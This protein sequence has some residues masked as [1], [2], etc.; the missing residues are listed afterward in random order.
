MA[1]GESGLPGREILKTKTKEILVLNQDKEMRSEL[2]DRLSQKGFAVTLMANLPEGE[3]ALEKDVYDLVVAHVNACVTECLSF[4][5]KGKKIQPNAILIIVA[6][7][8]S[9]SEAVKALYLGAADLLLDPASLDDVTAAIETT[10]LAKETGL[11]TSRFSR[12]LEG[13]ERTFTFPISEAPLGPTVDLL[14][15]NLVRAGVCTQI[16]QRLVAMAL[17]EALGNALYH[18]NLEIDPR[19][20]IDQGKEAFS[21]EVVKRL[22]DD[23]YKKRK[24]TVSY[25]ITPTEARF[26]IHD[27][28]EGFDH[29]NTKEGVTGDLAKSE[30]RGLLFLRSIMDE[31]IYNERGNEVTLVKRAV[32]KSS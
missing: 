27:D 28:G 13:E 25:K 3:K 22:S 5:E 12:F 30:G 2:G 19:L 31:V 14:T 15:E 6:Q 17:A 23:R 10:L 9:Y 1:T 8:L 29:N 21:K 20:K 26:V 4:L 24:T 7:K 32:E 16:E 11:H 18:G